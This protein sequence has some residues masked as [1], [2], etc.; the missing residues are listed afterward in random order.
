MRYFVKLA[1]IFC[2]ISLSFSALAG[3][4]VCINYG[5]SGCSKHI[6]DI[7]TDKFTKKFPVSNYEIVVVYDMHTMS[8]GGGVAFAIAGVSPRV[9]E[10]KY[11]S[12]EM[13]LMPINRYVVTKRIDANVQINPYRKTEIEIELLRD[14]VQMM[15]EE[16][17]RNANCNILKLK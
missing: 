13:A 16:C 11:G 8:N 1:A 5:N 7:V 2:F 17:D 14:A 15:M 3:P 9:S 4:Y 10:A 6:N 12:G